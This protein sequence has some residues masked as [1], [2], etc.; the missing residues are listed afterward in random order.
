[1]VGTDTKTPINVREAI[2]LLLISVVAIFLVGAEQKT[3]GWSVYGL[4]L[5]FHMLF[6]GGLFRRHIAL[7]YLSFGMLGLIPITTDISNEN[8][9]RMGLVLG[10]AL[11]LPYLVTRYYFKDNSVKFHWFNGRRWFRSEVIYILVTAVVAYFLLPFYLKNT[12]AYLNWGVDNTTE[13]ISRLFVGTNVLGFWDELFFISTILGLL[14][15]HMTF[16]IANMVQAVLFT[17]FLFELG[18]TGWA[19][20]VIYPFAL[21]Q[22][23]I[24]RKT[25][26]LFYVIAIHLTLDFILF[27]ALLNAHHPELANFFVT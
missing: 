21:S 17:S 18:F 11:A 4:G 16:R 3:I 22:G 6:T 8:F 13:S 9:I 20:L 7:I 10:T 2:S 12:G 19:P 24:F 15:R 1:M 25:D 5:V 27:L 23:Y 14:R 26:S